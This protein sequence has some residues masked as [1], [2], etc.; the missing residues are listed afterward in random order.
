MLCAGN[1]KDIKR[2]KKYDLNANLNTSNGAWRG[3]FD[4]SS[5]RCNVK[6]KKQ[7]LYSGCTSQC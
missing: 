4:I 5:D 7:L 6:K 1:S 3:V 2:R